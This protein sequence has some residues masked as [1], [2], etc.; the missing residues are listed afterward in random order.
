[1][2]P[3]PII[4]LDPGWLWKQQEH[5]VPRV[6]GAVSYGLALESVPISITGE[7]AKNASGITLTEQE[8]WTEL[9]T[10]RGKLAAAD[11]AE[12]LELFVYHDASGGG[13]YRK[14]KQVRPV[15]LQASIGDDRNVVFG[16]QLVLMAENPVIYT[17]APGS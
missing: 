5:K 10:L 1:V 2:L 9:E 17:T 8:M 15:S 3:Q 7:L 6:A 12:K 14:F 13:T 11:D 4:Q 16:Y